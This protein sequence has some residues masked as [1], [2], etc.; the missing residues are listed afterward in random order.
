[1]DIDAA[2]SL[3]LR[4]RALSIQKRIPFRL[5]FADWSALLG[6][7]IDNLGSSPGDCYIECIDRA[8][9]YVDGNVRVSRRGK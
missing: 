6:E 2:R 5:T 7:D 1:M 4:Q 9:G 3:Y 8:D